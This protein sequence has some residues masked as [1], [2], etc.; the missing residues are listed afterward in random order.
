[1][2][3][4]IHH[5]TSLYL[6]LHFTIYGCEAMLPSV[7]NQLSSRCNTLTSFTN[8]AEDLNVR[9]K[10]ITFSIEDVPI[11]ENVPKYAMCPNYDVHRK[12]N[13]DLTQ[14]IDFFY[15]KMQSS[16]E[17]QMDFYLIE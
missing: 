3:L 8:Y 4:N 9:R 17:R 16:T 6:M 1:M 11:I 13:D 15:S 14:V 10:I 5:C 12:K 7:G 2:V